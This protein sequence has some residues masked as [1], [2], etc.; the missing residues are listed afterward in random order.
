[1]H[2]IA[3]LSHWLSTRAVIGHQARL[4]ALLKVVEA[5][6][7]GGALALTQL[8]RSRR[9]AAFEK[10]HIKAVDRLL[11]NRHLHGEHERVYAALALQVLGRMERPVIVVDWSDFEPGRH[12]AML[13]AAVP[14]GGRAITIY[15]QVFPFK[16]YNS[17]GAHRE[18]LQALHRVVPATSRPIVVTDAGFRGP[19][20]RQVESY[21]WDW[22]GR[23]RNGIKYFNQE[24]GR[25]C[26]TDSLYARATLGVQHLGE[27]TLSRRCKYRFRLYLVRAHKLRVGRP[28]QGRRGIQPNETM[29]RRLHR[30]PW[31][32][33]TSLP[34]DDTAGARI[35]RVY[36][37]R[38][39]IEETFR[40]MK[41]HRWG[42]GLRYCRSR[43]AKRL[44]V[45]LLVAALATLALWLVGLAARRLGLS[46]RFQANTER[47][48]AVLSDVFVGRQLLRRERASLTERLLHDALNVLQS[49]HFNAVQT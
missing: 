1:M 42:L 16:R 47:R 39:Q 34:H 44:Q 38:M 43:S 10:H 8:G 35:K 4:S 46:R 11:G 33:A 2:A 19:W 48:R 17:P 20:F 9:G 23:I 29:Y 26:Y 49:L 25:W 41:S 14:V 37:S 22:V 15:E 12:W 31:L 36:A 18:F 40:D 21:G 28:R 6:L 5:A 30:A 7:R 24:T 45:L 32:L 13:K 27:V 3:V